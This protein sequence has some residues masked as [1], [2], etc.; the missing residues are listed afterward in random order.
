[1]KKTLVITKKWQELT[2]T[3]F[4]GK[5]KLIG[6]FSNSESYLVWEF[7]GDGNSAKKIFGSFLV[8]VLEVEI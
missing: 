7:L 3:K 6:E 8:K 1:M 5:A 2:E 4:L